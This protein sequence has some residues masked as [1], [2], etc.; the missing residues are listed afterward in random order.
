MGLLRVVAAS[1]A[2]LFFFVAFPAGAG[3]RVG[4]T[5]VMTAPGSPVELQRYGSR[6]TGFFQKDGDRLDVILLVAANGRVLRTG[7]RLVDGQHLALRQPR[8]GEIVEIRRVADTVEVTIAKGFPRPLQTAGAQAD[9][10]P[11]MTA[12]LNSQ[13]LR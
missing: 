1:L 9:R 11:R 10:S 3:D 2:C 7:A 6:V 12:A 4:N 5:I 13:G 8:N